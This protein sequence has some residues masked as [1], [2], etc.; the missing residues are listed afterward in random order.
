M[1]LQELV[2]E[3]RE[4]R[5][6]STRVGSLEVLITL[7]AYPGQVFDVLDAE[8]QDDRLY[9]KAGTNGRPK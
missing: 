4:Q 6:P 8:V 9:L 7:E 3:A 2:S 1:K 5:L